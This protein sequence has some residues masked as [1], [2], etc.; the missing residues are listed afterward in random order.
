MDHMYFLKPVEIG[1]IISIKGTVI[2]S[3]E[4]KLMVEVINEVILPIT[5]E[6]QTTNVCYFTFAIFK[7]KEISQHVPFV[8]PHTYEDGLK[9]LDGAKRYKLGERKRKNV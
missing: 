1:S 9:Y 8:L 2:Y 7:N 5:G 3:E 4:N 6:K